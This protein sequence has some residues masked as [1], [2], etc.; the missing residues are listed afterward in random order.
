MKGQINAFNDASQSMSTGAEYLY[1]SVS[2]ESFG[3]FSEVAQTAQVVLSHNGMK[4]VIIASTLSS[5]RLT[6]RRQQP[7]EV[8]IGDQGAG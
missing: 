8:R 4:Y 7:D 3:A 6:R 2:L 5:L 1:I